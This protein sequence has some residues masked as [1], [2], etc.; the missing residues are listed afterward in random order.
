MKTI[1]YQILTLSLILFALKIGYTQETVTLTL[2]VNTSNF[3]ADNL[4]ASCTF[5]A[6][7]SN[8]GQVIRSNGNLEYFTIEVKVGDI[9]VWEGISST[10]END[11]IDIKRIAQANN[12]R[13]FNNERNDGQMRGN[14]NK[15]TVV[16]K[17]LLT[18]MVDLI[19]NT[20]FSLK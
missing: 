10:S 20:M 7:W 12:T 5:E 17:V 13:I 2:I 6:Q 15:E 18:L 16:D 3:N 9:I 14:S 19:T 11:V 4:N 8:S 1:K